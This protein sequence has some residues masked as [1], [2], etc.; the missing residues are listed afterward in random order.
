M[1]QENQN[2]HDTAAL[3][4]LAGGLNVGNEYESPTELPAEEHFAQ[5]LVSALD[6][7]QG[8]YASDDEEFDAP[9][10]EPTE[11]VNGSSPSPRRARMNQFAGKQK[12]HA[13]MQFRKTAIPLLLVMALV[14]VALGV[15][16][17]IKVNQTDPEVVADNPFLAN[18]TLFAG[19]SIALGVCLIAGGLFFQYEVRKHHKNQR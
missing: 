16:T 3:R 14:L 19:V 7:S 1:S 12:R 10:A 9:A 13:G 17:L 11:E 2:L 6:D 4:A 18:G 15:V 8:Q 5:G